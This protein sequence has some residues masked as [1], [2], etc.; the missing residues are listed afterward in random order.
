MS[1]SRTPSS[2]DGRKISRGGGGKGKT[3]PKKR[4]IKRPST[5]SVSYEN[6]GRPRLPLP[7]AADVHDNST[8]YSSYLP[9]V[10]SAYIHWNKILKF[11]E[12]IFIVN[13]LWHIIDHSRRRSNV[14]GDVR[15]W[16]CPKLTNL[17]KSNAAFT[18]NSFDDQE[19]NLTFA[20]P[21]L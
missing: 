19:R 16:I 17:P 9:V 13:C 18:L 8:E 5:L 21:C 12:D 6:P 10:L 3:R 4:T 2:I 15:F 7:T 20:K 11:F 14:F 1:E